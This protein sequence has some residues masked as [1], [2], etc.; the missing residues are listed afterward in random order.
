MTATYVPTSQTAFSL[1]LGCINKRYMGRPRRQSAQAFNPLLTFHVSRITP[2]F[3]RVSFSTPPQGDSL[4][5][6][7]ALAYSASPCKRELAV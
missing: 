3:Q 4:A 5:L 7:K 2:Q 1:V 6:D